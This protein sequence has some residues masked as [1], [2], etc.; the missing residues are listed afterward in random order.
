MM[1]E[2]RLIHGFR[3]ELRALLLTACLAAA[4]ARDPGHEASRRPSFPTRGPDPRPMKLV[5]AFPLLS[6]ERPTFLARAPDRTDRLFVLEQAG[7]IR[8]FPK[9][10]DA[11]RSKTFLD[12]SDRVTPFGEQGLLGMAFDP[13]FTRNGFFYLHYSTRDSSRIARFRVDATDPDRA[14]PGSQSILLEVVQPAVNHN[15]GMLAFGP[16]DLLYIALGDGGGGGDPWKNAQNTRT[17]LGSLLRI[18]PHG[19]SGMLRYGIPA[20]NPLVGVGGG[21]RGEIWAHGLRNPWR[22]SFDS[23]TGALWLGDVGQAAREEVDRIVKG[24]NYGWPYFEGSVEFENPDKLPPDRFRMPVLDYERPSGVSVIGGYVYRGSRFQELRGAYVYGDWTGRVW[25]LAEGRLPRNTEIAHL[26]T[27]LSSFG[28]DRDGE[29]YL[30]AYAA[31][32]IL[33]LDRSDAAGP[34]FPARLSETDLF[35]DLATL[36]VHG[37]TLEYTVASELWSDRAVKRRWIVLPPGGRIGFAA[38][39]S[40]T[41]PTGTVL[42]KHF[43]L[44]TRVGDP[45]SR[46]RLETRV[47]VHEEDAWAGYTYRWNAAQTDADLLLGRMEESITIHDP[48]APGGSRVQRWTYPSRTDCLRCHGEASGR[49]LGVRTR[50]LNHQSPG[51]RREQLESWNALGTFDRDIG[52]AAQYPSMPD[53]RDTEASRRDRSRAYLAANCAMCHQPGGQ[54]PD[55]MDLRYATP[56]ART[57]LIGVPATRGSLGL[58]DPYRVKK[59]AKESS[60]LWERLRRRDDARMPPLGS[61]LPD[62]RAVELLGRWIDAMR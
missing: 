26:G 51:T 4:C 10:R 9:R 25:A 50:Q 24:S 18:D 37:G 33:S 41:F 45:S 12:I 15:G 44:E 53:P 46:R 19:R 54:A 43:E 2:N 23:Q 11:Q 31:G 21:V 27:T 29:L 17:L 8:V 42:I 47:L 13:A 56:A 30:V 62:A 20:D 52:S 7:R 48:S 16:D 58:V 59:G 60:V 40:W 34:R 35:R 49:V 38:E 39:G 32:K 5:A 28:E 22:F 55:D 14:D 57:K 6:F 1:P 61:H 36:S 3:P